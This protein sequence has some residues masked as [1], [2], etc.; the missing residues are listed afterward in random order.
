MRGNWCKHCNEFVEIKKDFTSAKIFGI[1]QLIAIV[2]GFL[3][4]YPWGGLIALG[5]PVILFFLTD[6][7]IVYVFIG[8]RACII[9]RKTTRR[10]RIRK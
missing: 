8:R 7:Y 9:C 10:K 5:L 6:G 1:I 3:I 2:I 4:W